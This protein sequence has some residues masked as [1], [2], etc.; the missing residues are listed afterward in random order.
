MVFNEG[1][2]LDETGGDMSKDRRVWQCGGIVIIWRCFS[3]RWRMDIWLALVDDLS[4]LRVL[5]L[6]GT[7]CLAC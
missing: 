1:D 6:R 5:H 4:F 2:A 3:Q 7:A